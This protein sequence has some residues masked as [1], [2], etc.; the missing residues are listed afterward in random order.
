M[1]PFPLDIA[2]SFHS[3]RFFQDPHMNW[4]FPI[5]SIT[6]KQRKNKILN[7]WCFWKV[8]KFS[9]KILKLFC[10]KADPD[11]LIW[12][13]KPWYSIFNWNKFCISH[14]CTMH[15]LLS[16]LNLVIFQQWMLESRLFVYLNTIKILQTHN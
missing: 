3:C 2:L 12:I 14:I 4:I 9:T 15:N 11:S 13:I 5:Y 1:E 7:I 6:K 8:Y 16:H 10:M